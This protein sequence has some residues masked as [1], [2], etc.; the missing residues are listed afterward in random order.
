M[1]KNVGIQTLRNFIFVLFVLIALPSI[2]QAGQAIL[3]WDA[4]T[5]NADGTPLTDLT[6]YKIYSG[7]GTGNYTQT[8]DVGNVTSYTANQPNR[9]AYLLLCSYC[10]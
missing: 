2:G 8:I 7:T 4:P 3:S 6:G 1:S 5:T 10:L 9:W